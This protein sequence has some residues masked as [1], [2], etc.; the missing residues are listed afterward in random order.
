MSAGPPAAAADSTPQRRL[1]I[2]ALAVASAIVGGLLLASAGDLWESFLQLRVRGDAMT[3]ERGNVAATREEV[4]R[5]FKQGVAMLHMRQYTHAMTAFH[6]VLELAPQMPEVHVNM[7]FALLGQGQHKAAAD[8]FNSALALKVDQANAY[9]GLALALEGQ[10]DVE[11][12]LGAMRTFAHL[13]RPDDPYREKAQALMQQL[14]EAVQQRR[15]TGDKGQG[16]KQ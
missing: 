14:D 3:R 8:F 2:A 7:G 6:R 5:R 4:E 10:G 9:Y 1:R 16:A 13:A 12:A 15:A 11:A